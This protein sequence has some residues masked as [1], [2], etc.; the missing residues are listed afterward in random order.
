MLKHRQLIS[1]EEIQKRISEMAT[2]F[3]EEYKGRTI[4]I[5][6]VLN[7]AIFFV[8]D[9]SRQLTVPVRLHFVRVS[10]YEL[11]A[12]SSGQVNLH[13][14][15]A[16]ELHGLDVILFEDILDTGIT[17]DYLVKHLREN[18]PRSIKVCVL[19]DKPEK[20]KVDVQPDYVGFRIPDEFVVG[21]GLDYQG[22]G[23]NLR[24]IAVLD[25]SEY[26]K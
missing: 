15:S 13:F 14:T 17:L 2:V 1:E 22:L 11:G 18:E 20:R 19:M 26:R 12:E 4:D 3:N 23:R 8:A 7:G 6:C 5:I 25:P 16:M 21:Y 9:L 10:S 24:Y